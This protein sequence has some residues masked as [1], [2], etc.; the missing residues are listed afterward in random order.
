M[1]LIFTLQN[2]TDGKAVISI[3]VIISVNVT[4]TTVV[5][6]FF[7]RSVSKIWIYFMLFIALLS[8]WINY[9]IYI[10]VNN[11]TVSTYTETPLLMPCVNGNLSFIFDVNGNIS[12]TP[13]LV[14][15]KI[16]LISP[17]VVELLWHIAE[18]FA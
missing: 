4:I 13:N 12:F 7:H 15:I 9:I 6:L 18:T 14:G 2:N 3:N 17:A 5:L 11:A 8:N 1:S 16:L 10:L